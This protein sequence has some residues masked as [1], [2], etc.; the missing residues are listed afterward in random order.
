MEH[1]ALAFRVMILAL[2][3]SRGPGRPN[4]LRQKQ[5]F[6]GEE[7][8]NLCTRRDIGSDDSGAAT[9]RPLSRSQ[10]PD[11]AGDARSMIAAK[12]EAIHKQ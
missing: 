9:S 11:T 12:P 7:M 1:E 6:K 10:R 5:T 2:F 4:E 8:V 3:C